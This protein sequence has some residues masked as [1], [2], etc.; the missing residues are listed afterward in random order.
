MVERRYG[1]TRVTPPP[2]QHY[3]THITR[4]VF[5][6]VPLP[7]ADTE[8]T[9]QLPLGLR[10]FTL[11][12]RDGSPLRLA[13]EREKVVSSNPPYF[14]LKPDTFWT[15]QN[16]DI[17]NEKCILYIASRTAGKIVEIIAGIEE[18]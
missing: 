13:W 11:Q 14:T 18:D 5:I 1:D 2:R 10:T 15:E 6:E 8:Y 9:W 7:S 4:L 17:Q 16:L 3:P 12:V